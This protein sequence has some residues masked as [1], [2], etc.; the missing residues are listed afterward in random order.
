VPPPVLVSG[1]DGR[2]LGIEASVLRRQGQAIEEFAT[3]R[4]L[5]DAL[6]TEGGRLVVLGPRLSDLALPEA[7][8]RLRQDPVTRRVSI[9]GLVPAAADSAMEGAVLE[10][11]ANAVLRRPFP[12]WQLDY[13]VA[14]LLF[15]PPR[16]RSRVPVQGQVVGTPRASST[17]HFVGLSRNISVN[18]ILLASPVILP[19]SDLELEISLPSRGA[20]RVLGRVVRHA[21]EVGWPY[22]GYGIE[23]LYL[24]GES[25]AAIISLVEHEVAPHLPAM[26]MSSDNDAAT[27]T[28]RR[29]GW[30]YELLGP[31]GSSDRW[32]VEIRRA[33]RDRWRPGNAG[34]FYVVEDVTPQAALEAARSFVRRHG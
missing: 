3:L 8:R 22:L 29:E 6:A 1:L 33:P 13:W 17:G 20:H 30:V 24:A 28:V 2:S 16:A 26:V 25:Q 27:T 23:F 32:Q 14:K 4:Q 15:I 12:A 21:P 10:A 34:P 18:G 19:G 5:Q 11:G 9:L 31:V 7:I